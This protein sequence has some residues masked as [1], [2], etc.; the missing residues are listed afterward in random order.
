M[1]A[2]HFKSSQRIQIFTIV[3]WGIFE[4]FIICL[5]PFT[6]IRDELTIWEPPRIGCPP[7][8][9]QRYSPPR[10]V[11]WWHVMS[12]DQGLK[13]TIPHINLTRNIPSR[14]LGCTTV[15]LSRLSSISTGDCRLKLFAQEAKRKYVATIDCCRHGHEE[16]LWSVCAQ[17]SYLTAKEQVKNTTVLCCR[18]LCCILNTYR[19]SASKLSTTKENK[20]STIFGTL[21]RRTLSSVPLLH[22]C[23]HQQSLRQCENRGDLLRKTERQQ[24]SSSLS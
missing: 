11:N 7:L 23:W 24:T 16:A 2:N 20:I 12:W 9:I 22:V 3:D 18:I 4:N 10:P 17:P 5:L 19:L 21:C 1:S 13:R 8:F 6:V 14:K 15:N